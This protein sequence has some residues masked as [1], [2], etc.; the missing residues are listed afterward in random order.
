[1]KLSK[2]IAAA[3]AAASISA[4]ASAVPITT[5]IITVVDESGSMGG[6]A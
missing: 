2:K 5:D 1:M 3:I 6:G 4:G